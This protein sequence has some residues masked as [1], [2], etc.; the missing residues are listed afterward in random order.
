MKSVIDQVLS[1]KLVLNLPPSPWDG[2]V[3]VLYCWR[4]SVV[5]AIMIVEMISCQ[6][7]TLR[8]ISA[9]P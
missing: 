9:S 6:T 7:S 3:S 2:C 8:Q 1:V 5:G 4:L